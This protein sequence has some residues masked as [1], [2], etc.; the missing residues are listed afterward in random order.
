MKPT[1]FD[2]DQ[3]R[4]YIPYRKYIAFEGKLLD[5]E[6]EYW[7]DFQMP[8]SLDPVRFYFNKKDSDRVEKILK[9][10]HF[11]TTDDFSSTFDYRQSRKFYLLY[12][13][14]FVALFI[15]G[16]ILIEAYKMFFK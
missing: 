10:N 4:I 13:I 14:S 15:L 16:F 8:G 2:Q 5:S 3:Y 6:I 7:I 12:I 1:I 11:L 9:E